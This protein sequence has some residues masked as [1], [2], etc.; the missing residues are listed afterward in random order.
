[1]PEVSF[2]LTERFVIDPTLYLCAP[3]RYPPEKPPR[4]IEKACSVIKSEVFARFT[5]L[6]TSALAAPDA[7]IHFSTGVYK[8]SSLLL[9]KW[10][11]I[12]SAAGSSSEVYAHFRRARLFAVVTLIGSLAGAIWPGVLKYFRY[13]PPPPP[14][15]E[16]I[17]PSDAPD[18]IVA[19]SKAVQEDKEKD[20]F[21]QLRNFWEKSSLSD[22]H[23]FVQIFNQLPEPFKAVRVVLADMV[24]RSIAVSPLSQKQIKWLNSNEVTW[25]GNFTFQDV[26][27]S[28]NAFFFHATSEKALESILKS[29]KIEV[30]HEKAYRGAFVST[31]PEYSFGPCVL[32]FKR[33]IERVSKL[34]HGFTINQETYWAGFSHDIPVTQFTLACVIIDTMYGNEQDFENKCQK[35][36]GWKITIESREAIRWT[37]DAI[38]LLNMG[39]PKE[40]PQEGEAA[41]QNILQAMKLAVAVPKSSNVTIQ[42]QSVRQGKEKA[43]VPN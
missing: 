41:G 17:S 32:A 30:R 36:A 23:W 11:R 13:S 31:Q 25:N 29:K 34:E 21:P 24:Y 19:L 5:A 6:F 42:R 37:L 26:P 7:L 2:S 27:N 43:L 18:A 3:L 16:S 40:W 8:G 14:N 12:G 4:F 1:M 39:I 35:W 38:K 33:N 28:R 10:T 15:E 20:P 9:K 22:K